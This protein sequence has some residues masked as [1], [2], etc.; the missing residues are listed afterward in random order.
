M[1]FSIDNRASSIA[2]FMGPTWGP[3]GADRTQVG[4]MLTRWAFPSGMVEINRGVRKSTW[5]IIIITV[6]SHECPSNS[7]H[8][9]IE[10][11]FKNLFRLTLRTYQR[12]TLLAIKAESVSM[13]WRHYCVTHQTVIKWI[14]QLSSHRAQLSVR[15]KKT[16]ISISHQ[17]PLEYR[18]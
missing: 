3:S 10:Y 5:Y 1:L 7:N 9:Q 8:R 14:F 16:P 18:G 12:S 6:L 2:R 15:H 4:P 11:L 13:S 17:F